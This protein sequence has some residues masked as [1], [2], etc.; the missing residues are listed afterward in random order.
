MLA[1]LDALSEEEAE[2]LLE[3]GA[4]GQDGTRRMNDKLAG[5]SPAKRA[6]SSG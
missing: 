2:R 6:L 1:E 3:A 5:L 4:T